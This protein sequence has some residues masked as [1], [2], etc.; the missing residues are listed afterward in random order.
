MAWRLAKG[1]I[2]LRDQVNKQ[3]PLRSKVSDGTR[4]DSA[5]ASRKSDHNE[6]SRGI[7]HALDL[8]HDP[9]VGFDSYKFADQLLARQDPRLSYII[10]NR[11]I[12]S[13]PSGVAPGKWRPYSG[14]NAHSQHVHISIRGPGFEDETFPW[15]IDMGPLVLVPGAA[16]PF[17][18]MKQGSSGPKVA[19]LQVLVG[20]PA[21]GVFGPKTKARVAA[22][23]L[24]NHLVA[25]GIVGPQTWQLI[26]SMNK[27]KVA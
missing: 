19:E 2:T 18:V 7:V 8:T 26:S 23:Q 20:L 12:G 27:G 24:E 21:D 1:L 10:S 9:R 16:A 3:Y 14:V 4:G 5:H 13:G 22:L 15:N 17:P 6:D 25:D 11:R